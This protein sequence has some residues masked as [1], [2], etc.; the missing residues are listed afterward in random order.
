MWEEVRLMQ[1]SR[2]IYKHRQ[3]SGSGSTGAALVGA[4]PDHDQVNGQVINSEQTR[5]LGSLCI[6]TEVSEADK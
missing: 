6:C 1:R 4:V 2:V 5:L 3:G